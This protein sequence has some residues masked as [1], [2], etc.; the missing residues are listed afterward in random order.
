MS[1]ADFGA[2]MADVVEGVEL[3]V[4]AGVPPGGA[5][6]SCAEAGMAPSKRPPIAANVDVQ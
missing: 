5:F 3:V 2:E 4:V 6:G 1:S